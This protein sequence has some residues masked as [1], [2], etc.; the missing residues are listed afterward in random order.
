MDKPKPRSSL[1]EDILIGELERGQV[2]RDR[3]EQ[4]ENQGTE[5]ANVV[6]LMPY[7]IH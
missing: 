2:D 4:E 3:V 1:S 6:S 7:D 5:D